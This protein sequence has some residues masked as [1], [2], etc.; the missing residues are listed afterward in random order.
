MPMPEKPLPTMAIRGAADRVDSAD[1]AGVT[2]VSGKGNSGCVRVGGIAPYA[3]HAANLLTGS[4]P[5]VTRRVDNCTLRV[6]ID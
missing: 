5:N 1:E 6:K 2:A 3:R 4:R